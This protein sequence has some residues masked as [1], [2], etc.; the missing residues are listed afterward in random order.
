MLLTVVS[1]KIKAWSSLELFLG[2]KA[3]DIWVQEKKWI[4]QPGY[5]VS[6]IH[7]PSH[8]YLSTAPMLALTGVQVSDEKGFVLWGGSVVPSPDVGFDPILAAGLQWTWTPRNGRGM[9]CV[10]LR[11]Q[12]CFAVKSSIVLGLR[13][14]EFS[15]SEEIICQMS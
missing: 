8:P 7:P 6:V 12:I 13:P 4:L 11:L 10:T 3:L 15:P 2:L 14:W 5:S 1:A 9:G